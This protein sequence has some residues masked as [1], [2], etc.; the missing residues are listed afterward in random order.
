MMSARAIKTRVLGSTNTRPTRIKA[1]AGPMQSLTV[2]IVNLEGS[3]EECH[4]KIAT[5]LA[6]KLG[7]LTPATYLLG[8]AYKGDYYFVFS[9]TR[10]IGIKE[11][12][13]PS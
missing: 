6:T 8:G 5:R 2:G 4:A 1:S 9:D 3:T 12:G 7:W 11:E 13:E 10:I